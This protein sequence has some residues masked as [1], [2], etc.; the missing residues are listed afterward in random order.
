[1]S[2]KSSPDYDLRRKAF[3]LTARKSCPEKGHWPALEDEY[4]EKVYAVQLNRD[5][6][7]PKNNA[8]CSLS[9]KSEQKDADAEFDEKACH[10]I[11]QL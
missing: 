11:D 9:R 5:E 2:I 6:S 10:D 3:P 7:Y 1:M 8:M 4:K